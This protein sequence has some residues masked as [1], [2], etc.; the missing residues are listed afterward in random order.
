M[1]QEERAE[2]GAPW[3]GH[4]LFGHGGGE[5]YTV[6]HDRDFHCYPLIGALSHLVPEDGQRPRKQLG[7]GQHFQGGCPSGS[8]SAAPARTRG[9]ARRARRG[10]WRRR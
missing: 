6:E 3:D 9:R 7:L 10:C 1:G 8:A 2:G 5:C 4:R